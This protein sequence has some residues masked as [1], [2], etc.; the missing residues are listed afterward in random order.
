MVPSLLVNPSGGGTSLSRPSARVKP[1]KTLLFNGEGKHLKLRRQGLGSLH[2]LS[3]L[4]QS[5]SQHG[6]GS[7]Q[8]ERGRIWE[9]KQSCHSRRPFWLA[10]ILRRQLGD[11]NVRQIKARCWFLS[12]WRF[13]NVLCL[14]EK[15]PV[16]SHKTLST[17]TFCLQCMRRN[18]SETAQYGSICPKRSKKHIPNRVII[19]SNP[20]TIGN[21]R[22]R[23]PTTWTVTRCILSLASPIQSQNCENQGQDWMTMDPF[24]RWAWVINYSAV[25]ISHPICK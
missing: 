13:Q 20:S 23:P 15:L 22:T 16:T 24:W 19:L 6:D 9:K 2:F 1:Y 17:C 10:L 7:R 14:T 3:V 25:T 18:A 8:S 5:L 4:Y 11:L 12:T 21:L